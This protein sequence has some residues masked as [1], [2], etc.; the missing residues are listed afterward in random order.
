MPCGAVAKRTFARPLRPWATASPELPPVSDM[1]RPAAPLHANPLPF[2]TPADGR[3]YDSV[4]RSSAAAGLRCG[5]SSANRQCQSIRLGGRQLVAAA[6]AEACLVD[7]IDAV[8]ELPDLA[9]VAASGS[10]RLN[11]ASR[12]HAH[13]CRRSVRVDVNNDAARRERPRPAATAKMPRMRPA[14]VVPRHLAQ[15]DEAR[16]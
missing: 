14:D 15:F 13:D 3:T 1:L 5:W 11:V 2:K 4:R 8:G 6:E 16:R 10:P 12:S 7:V 9:I